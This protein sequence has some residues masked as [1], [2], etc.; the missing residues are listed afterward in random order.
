MLIIYVKSIF[1]TFRRAAHRGERG[2]AHPINEI[3]L[4]STKSRE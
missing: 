3:L 4:Q 1:S 2:N